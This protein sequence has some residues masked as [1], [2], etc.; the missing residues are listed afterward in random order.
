MRAS[1][2]RVPEQNDIKQ[3]IIV[4]HYFRVVG[5]GGAEATIAPP[6]FFEIRKTRIK[7]R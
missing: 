1:T 5:P 6:I 3:T 2:S 4:I 7:T